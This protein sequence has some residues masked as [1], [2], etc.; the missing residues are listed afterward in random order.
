MTIG[1]MLDTDPIGEAHRLW[2]KH[3]WA[4]AADGM[5]AVTSLVRAQQIMMQRIDVVLRP[6]NLTFARYEILMLLG[7]SRSGSLPMTRMGSLLQ[8]HPTSVTSAVDRLEAQGFVERL[9]HPSDRRAVLASVT[10]AGRAQATSAT[11]ALNGQV[12]ENLG[13]TDNQVEQLR[14]VLRSFR[15]NAGDF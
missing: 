10:D 13:I 1:K 2:V 14:G 5:A 3:G 9:P 8:V 4:D 6:L 12:F 15:A 7:F 11:A